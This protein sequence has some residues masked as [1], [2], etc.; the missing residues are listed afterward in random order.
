[1]TMPDRNDAAVRVED[2]TFSYGA[3]EV[4]HGIAFALHAGEVV[5]L[6]GPNGAASRSS[7]RAVSSRTDR[8]IIGVA[9]FGTPLA[10]CSV[11]AR[12]QGS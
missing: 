11:G 1:M 9:V 6:L 10:C 3:G 2:L 4:L 8:S 7:T 5:G 12:P